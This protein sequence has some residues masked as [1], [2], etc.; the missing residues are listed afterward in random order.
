MRG[1][2]IVNPNAKENR[3]WM[4]KVVSLSCSL[5]AEKML[6]RRRALEYAWLD[7][8]RSSADRNVD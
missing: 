8:W 1:I 6:R 4:A 2:S 5:R 7:L 3:G